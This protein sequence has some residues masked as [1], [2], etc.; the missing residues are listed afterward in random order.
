MC[1][2][3]MTLPS[4]LKPKPSIV[5]WVIGGLAGAGLYKLIS[6]GGVSWV[7]SA[8]LIVSVL[9]ITALIAGLFD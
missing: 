1:D 3:T 4:R 9:L 7:V 2:W 8:I 5:A 6:Q